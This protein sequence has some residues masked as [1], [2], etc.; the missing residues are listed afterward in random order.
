MV[1][2]GYGVV[3]L[4]ELLVSSLGHACW[5]KRRSSPIPLF[6]LRMIWL[7]EA[8]PLVLT[9]LFSLHDVPRHGLD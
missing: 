1:A 3:T 4:P 5:I 8:T 6:P 7:R 9:Q 2:A